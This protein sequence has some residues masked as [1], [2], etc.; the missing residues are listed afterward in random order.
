[1]QPL[2]TIKGKESANMQTIPH[3]N[4][5][6]SLID[7]IESWCGPPKPEYRIADT[8]IP[9]FVPDP[10]RAIYAS[11][12]NWPARKQNPPP[13]PVK[14]L[15]QIQDWLYPVDRLKIQDDRFAFLIEN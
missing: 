3:E 12:G 5:I 15:L 11:L 13:H 4:P 2:R 14:G 1:M 7:F 10:L 8:E 9:D 6:P